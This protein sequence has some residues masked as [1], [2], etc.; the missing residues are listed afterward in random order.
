VGGGE[1]IVS[2]PEQEASLADSGVA[3]QDELDQIVEGCP[4]STHILK[5][6]YS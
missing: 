3:N 4:F 6:V 2:E 1:V 5:F